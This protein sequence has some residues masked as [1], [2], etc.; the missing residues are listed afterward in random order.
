MAI[1]A[2]GPVAG[3][4]ENRTAI[5]RY[6]ATH[7]VVVPFKATRIAAASASQ[8]RVE[9]SMSVKGNV[10]TPEGQAR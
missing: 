6:G 1:I 9:P 4:L 10:T 8:R 5:T 7:H 2:N 3:V